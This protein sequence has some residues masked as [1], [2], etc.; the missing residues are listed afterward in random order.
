[1]ISNNSDSK[2][3]QRAKKEGIARYH[4]SGKTH[5]NED[6]LDQAILDVLI[7][8]EV[9]HVVLAG[10]MKKLG[11]SVLN[12]FHNRVLNI[13]PSLLPKFGGHGLFGMRVHEAVLEAGE[14]VTGATVHIVSEEYDEGPILGQAHI[15]IRESDTPELLARRVRSQEHILFP[16]VL[17]QI[18]TGEII[19]PD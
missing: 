5:P 2:A 14:Q 17:Q 15:V 3:L 7:K 11:S 16:K 18:V 10:Y 1:V 19:L 4:L 6:K 8:H 13:H 12:H 9:D